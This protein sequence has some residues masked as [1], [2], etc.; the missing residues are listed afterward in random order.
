MQHDIEKADFSSVSS[1]GGALMMFGTGTVSFDILP[2][3]LQFA[4]QRKAMGMIWPIQTIKV[5]T[6]IHFRAFLSYPMI[7]FQCWSFNAKETHFGSSEIHI[8]SS[9]FS[10]G[11]FNIQHWTLGIPVRKIQHSISFQSMFK[12]LFRFNIDKNHSSLDGKSKRNNI[13]WKDPVKKNQL[14]NFPVISS[15]IF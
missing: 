7:Q 8:G 2:G 4:S 15:S 6:L 12:L 3:K 5:N 11:Y 13:Q 1:L 10:L 14:S 9:Y